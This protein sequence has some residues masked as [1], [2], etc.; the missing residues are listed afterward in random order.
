VLADEQLPKNQSVI[1]AVEPHGWFPFGLG[2]VSQGATPGR[3]RHPFRPLLGCPD[4]PW[5]AEQAVQPSP[6]SGRISGP[7]IPGE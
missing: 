1:Y 2:A 4:L 3:P 7:P 6:T 5:A